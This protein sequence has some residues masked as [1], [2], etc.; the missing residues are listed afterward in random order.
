M[1]LEELAIKAV[2]AAEAADVDFMV[3]GAIAAGAFGVPRSTSDVDLLLAMNVAGGLEAVIKALEPLV[4]FEPQ[5]LFDTLTWGRRHVGASRTSPPYKIELFE[6]FDEPFVQEEF[7]R[8]QQVFVPMLGR[9]TWLPTPED[10]IV[11]KLRW[12]RN[13]DLD[14]ARDVLAV[15]GP[16]SL[17]MEYIRGWCAKHGTTERLEAALAGIPPL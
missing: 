7:R 12:G 10:V 1:T 15:Q 17:D 2:E 13:K 4:Q 6:L 14:D 3:V 8:R 11:Q 16:E 5:V 9:S